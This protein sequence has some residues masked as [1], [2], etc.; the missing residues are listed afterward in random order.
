MSSP[1][2]RWA[3]PRALLIELDS[4]DSVLALH[5]RLLASPPAGQVDVLAAARTVL[6]VFDSRAS[7]QAARAA[8]AHL[9]ET[10]A[11][12]RDANA[13]PVRMEVVY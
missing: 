7:A 1:R 8:V 13:E 5:A 10:E 9:E 4:L 2:I 11:A 12:D 6:A 3:G